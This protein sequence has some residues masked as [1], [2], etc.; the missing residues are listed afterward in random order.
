MAKR[1][2]INE[3]KSKTIYEGPTP[4]TLIQY[5]RDDLIAFGGKK[6][7]VLSG[8]GVLNNRISAH[9]MS[10]LETIGITT[11]FIKC[12]NMRE[13]LVHNLE[14]VPFKMVVRNI[15]A[16]SICDRL[17][18]KEGTILPRPIIEYYHIDKDKKSPMINESHIS[19]FG[20]SDPYEL[21]EINH[22]TYRI[23]D[24]LNGLFEGIGITLVDFKLE[25]GRLWGEY[26]EL[27]IML[28]DEISPDSCRLW[29]TETK[30]KMDK[31][32]FRYDLGDLTAGYQEIAKRL[33]LVPETGI[34]EGG[35]INEQLAASLIDIENELA[36]HRELRE[37][38]KP[39]KPKPRKI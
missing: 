3:G 28:A 20:W 6:H 21:E 7:E 36:K 9:L 37:I 32:R 15:A 2:I 5:F 18:I 11:H 29:D 17:N 12:L 31:D 25:F 24:Y 26:G 19:T 13:Q 27:Y 22:M 8:K 16:G 14:I 1:I 34:I 30:E 38:K 4:E 39:N 10:K 35:N 23:N 33:G